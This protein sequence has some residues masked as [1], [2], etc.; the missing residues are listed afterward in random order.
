MYKVVG[1]ICVGFA[2]IL[3]GASQLRANEY[4]EKYPQLTK[5]CVE[6]AKAGYDS[7]SFGKSVVSVNEIFEVALECNLSYYKAKN[8]VFGPAIILT[9]E[10]SSGSQVFQIKESVRQVTIVESQVNGKPEFVMAIGGLANRV[11]LRHI[12][13]LNEA[14]QPINAKNHFEGTVSPDEMV[15]A[16]QSGS[17]FR[18]GMYI[19]QSGIDAYKTCVIGQRDPVRDC[20]SVVAN[21][22]KNLGIVI[23]ESLLNSITLDLGWLATKAPNNSDLEK[24]AGRVDFQ[25][26]L[27]ELKRFIAADYSPVE[28]SEQLIAEAKKSLAE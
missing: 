1:Y 12:L 5:L 3:V 26:S 28:A 25:V 14:G 13:K 7:L 27:A 11:V 19:S 9:R 15:R 22:P 2:V 4:A 23:G 18:S 17:Q 6:K 16:G 10:V 21:Q 20:P 24:R 8:P